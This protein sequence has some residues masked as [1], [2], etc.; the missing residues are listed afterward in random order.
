MDVVKKDYKTARTLPITPK[1]ML[2]LQLHR[3]THKFFKATDIDE[4]IV[5]NNRAL[6]RVRIY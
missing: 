4:V 2:S 1:I 6:L 5:M 3:K